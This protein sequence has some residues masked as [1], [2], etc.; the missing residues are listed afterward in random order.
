[1]NLRFTE[2]NTSV[3]FSFFHL[4]RIHILP[5]L[6]S[7]LQ[8]LIQLLHRLLQPGEQ[9]RD[10]S[11]RWHR[12]DLVNLSTPVLLSLSSP[13]HPSPPSLSSLPLAGSPR[14]PEEAAS[15]KLAS[16]RWAG[17]GALLGSSLC[18]AAESRGRRAAECTSPEPHAVDTAE[19]SSLLVLWFTPY[20]CPAMQLGEDTLGQSAAGGAVAGSTEWG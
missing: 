13:T 7:L 10:V 11:S 2:N 6:G 16:G 15:H 12:G 9:T 20:H 17:G 18:L 1:M 3:L 14:P 4:P 5:S 8:L 19:K